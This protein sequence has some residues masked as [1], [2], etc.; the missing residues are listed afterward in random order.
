MSRDL[1]VDQIKKLWILDLIIQTGSLKAAALQAKITPSAVSQTITT[2]EKSI[3]KPLLIRNRQNIKPTPAALNILSVV[4]PAFEAFEKLKDLS[5]VSAPALTWVNFGTYESIAVDL[6]PRLLDIFREKLPKTRLGLRVARTQQLITMV[7]KGE[8][9]SALITETDNLEKFHQK[10]LFNDRLGFYTAKD[11][12]LLQSG[13]EAIAHY[14]YGSL[15][16]S[17]D[18]LP[19]YFVKFIKQYNLPKPFFYSDSFETLR[20]TAAAGNLIAVLPERVARRNEDLVEILP[21]SKPKY[22]GEHKL[23]LISQPSCD[24]EEFDFIAFETEKILKSQ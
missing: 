19:R 8:L 15:A 10:T 3:G 18:G 6:L 23:I 17:T 22:S 12:P 21:P 16:A 24:R 20:A 4:R 9:C 14:G 5:G 11:S 1:N 2:L 7:R 13:W